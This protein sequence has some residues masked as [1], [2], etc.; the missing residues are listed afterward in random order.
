MQSTKLHSSRG[1]CPWRGVG[2]AAHSDGE[3]QQ[4]PSPPSPP[5]AQSSGNHGLPPALFS[6][7]G[8]PQLRAALLLVVLLSFSLPR[9]Q[10]TSK[11][12]C[13][14]V[15]FPRCPSGVTRLL[16]PS[17]PPPSCLLQGLPAWP[18]LQQD[19]RSGELL[20]IIHASGKGTGILAAVSTT[21]SFV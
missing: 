2:V 8:P 17:L 21:L 6:K 15:S 7:E 1:R 5:A 14:P 9:L 12:P 10:H 3:V 16:A 19:P 4:P 20:R 18:P 13:P 11:T